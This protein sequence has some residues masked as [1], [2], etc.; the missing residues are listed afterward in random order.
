MVKEL[1][2]DNSIF[3]LGANADTNLSANDSA[4][5]SEFQAAFETAKHNYADKKEFD[6]NTNKVIKTAEK[7]IKTEH[8]TGGTCF[9]FRSAL[10]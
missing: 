7:T 8:S 2:M 4:P 5:A 10:V 9:I 3:S 6:T 1:S